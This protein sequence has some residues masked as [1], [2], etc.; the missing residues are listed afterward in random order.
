MKAYEEA[1]LQKALA[2]TFAGTNPMRIKRAS[3]QKSR[4]PNQALLRIAKQYGVGRRGPGVIPVESKKRVCP[5][6]HS[7]H[8]KTTATALSVPNREIFASE[9]LKAGIRASR[10]Q[11]VIEYLHW[12]SL[13]NVEKRTDS[14]ADALGGVSNENV[15]MLKKLYDQLAMLS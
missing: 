11:K 15:V 1:E 14:I 4:S 6:A 13:E 3:K 9:A 5:Q 7:S 12:C 8:D 10:V 2:K